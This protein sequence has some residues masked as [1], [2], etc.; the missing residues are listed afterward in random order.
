[1]L[2]ACAPVLKSTKTAAMNDHVVDTVHNV[3]IAMFNR[4]F[5]VFA[6]SMMIE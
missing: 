1:M 4:L 6:T 2:N 3:E 5:W